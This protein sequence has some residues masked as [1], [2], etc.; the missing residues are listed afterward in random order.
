MKKLKRS[1]IYL[2]PGK[3]AFSLDIRAGEDD[4]LKRLEDELKADYE[5]IAMNEIV[6]DLNEGGTIGKGCTVS[7]TLDAPSEAVSFDDNCVKCVQK[8]VFDLFGENQTQLTQ[9]MTSGAGHDSVYTSKRVPTSMIFV[10]CKD[11]ISHNPEEFCS[12]EDWYVLWRFTTSSSSPLYAFEPVIAATYYCSEKT[13]LTT[14]SYSATGAQVL[15]GAVLHYDK[16]RL[17]EKW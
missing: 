2:V 16:L 15:L 13:M 5:R 3:V 17:N 12:P 1:R 11:G 7:W 8:S 14:L 10:P 9:A 6:D 4:R